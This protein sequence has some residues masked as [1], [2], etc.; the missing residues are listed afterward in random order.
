MHAS[1]LIGFRVFRQEGALAP[2]N[3]AADVYAVSI[4]GL[5]QLERRLDTRTAWLCLT[6]YGH[7][8]QGKKHGR[9]S[10]NCANAIS[11]GSGCLCNAHYYVPPLLSALRA[12][13][14]SPPYIRPEGRSSGRPSGV[15]AME[16]D[17][18]AGL[19]HMHHAM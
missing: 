8:A 3:I 16:F 2:E 6:G 14:L 19:M 12:H 17:I 10:S 9:C 11:P 15:N 1:I 4:S 13:S 7:G 5:R 18:I